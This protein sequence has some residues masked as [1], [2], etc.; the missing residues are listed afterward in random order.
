MPAKIEKTSSIL[1]DTWNRF[2]QHK[3]GLIGGIVIAG[4]YLFFG[5]LGPF[6][7]PYAVDSKDYENVF[8]PPQ[9]VRF[10]DLEGHWKGGKEFKINIP[11]TFTPRINNC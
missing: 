9:R 4:L 2:K 5:L 10:R 3:L 7:A 8:A 1:R 6:I 11:T